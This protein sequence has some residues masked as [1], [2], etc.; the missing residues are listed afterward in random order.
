M[1]R[2]KILA[3]VSSVLVGCLGWLPAARADDVN[4]PPFAFFPNSVVLFTEDL[5][6]GLV[7]TDFNVFPGAFPLSDND[8][9]QGAGEPCLTI[10]TTPTGATTFLFE[11]PN[12]IDPLPV[13][14]VRIQVT[15]FGLL[16]PTIPLVEGKDPECPAG[17]CPGVFVQHV[18]DTAETP[19]A[20]YFFE[21]WFILP[22]PD[23]DRF[24]IIA[25][26][27]TTVH[28]VV[29]DTISFAVP[30]PS[31]L[32]LFG[33]GVWSLLGYGWWRGRRQSTAPGA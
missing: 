25:P 20:S 14:L 32:L 7:I 29:I 23:D 26:P 5:G 15:Y 30:A 33:G 3:V 27:G 31:T 13:K 21:D 6:Q 19:G 12:F 1:R 2:V 28:Q 16:D 9:G 17:D 11:M 10:A 22:N 4:P 18:V 24:G 8:C